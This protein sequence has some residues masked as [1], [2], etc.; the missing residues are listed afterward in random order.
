MCK[1]SQEGIRAGVSLILRGN[2][3]P[4]NKTLLFENHPGWTEWYF[5]LRTLDSQCH[6]MDRPRWAWSRIVGP[7]SSH[8]RVEDRV[9]LPAGNCHHEIMLRASVTSGFRKDGPS[10]G[11]V[12]GFVCS[13]WG[14][15][16]VALGD[17][18][19]ELRRRRSRARPREPTSKTTSFV[20]GD[21]C[22][23]QVS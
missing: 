3:G 1:A 4:W 23:R 2:R 6:V 14:W 7:C 21:W 20:N 11:I 17:L 5:G 10:I 15:W 22:C 8:R 19:P 13:I 16:H 18:A 9:E 12:R